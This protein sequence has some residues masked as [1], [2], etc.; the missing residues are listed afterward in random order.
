LGARGT[1]VVTANNILFSGDTGQTYTIINA[2][3][4]NDYMVNSDRTAV[5]NKKGLVLISSSIPYRTNSYTLGNTDESS[6]A[7]LIGNMAHVTPYQG[8]VNYIEMATDTRQTFIFRANLPHNENLPFGAE[9]LDSK[10]ENVGY[11]GQSGV[12]YIKSKSYPD[13]L[14]IKTNAARDEECIIRNPIDTMDK[15][16]NICRGQ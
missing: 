16:K 4:A 10:K 14:Y 9:V 2:P 15:N 5:T 13:I 8:S 6:G 1:A 11:V 3:M 7:D 12:L